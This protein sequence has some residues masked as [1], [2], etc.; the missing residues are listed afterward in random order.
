MA[1]R[2]SS[3]SCTT[4]RSVRLLQRHLH[5]ADRAVH[6]LL[7]RG[8]HRVGL[9]PAQHGARDFRRVGQVRETR[10]FDVQ[11]RLLEA[12]LQLVL[13]LGDDLVAAAAQRQLGVVVVDAS[14]R[15]THWRG[16]AA[17]LRPGSARRVR[18]CRCRAWRAPCRL[19]RQTTAAA[20]SIGLPRLSL[21]L[22]FSLLKLRSRTL[23][24][25]LL[26]NGFAQRRPV[27]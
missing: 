9:L 3:S 13:E 16:G 2:R 21:T 19:M 27:E 26:K 7:A 4:P 17:P 25:I 5:H 1:A 11:S 14:R 12:L 10:V 22:S 8:D 15:S 6:D 20:I 18:S 24:F 23:T